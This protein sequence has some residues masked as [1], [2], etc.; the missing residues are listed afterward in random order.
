MRVLAPQLGFTAGSRKSAILADLPEG[1][2]PSVTLCSQEGEI[3]LPVDVTPAERVGHWQ[4]NCFARADFSTIDRPGEYSLEIRWNDRTVKSPAF[5]IDTEVLLKSGASDVLVYFRASRSWGDYERKDAAAS[6]F[7]HPEWGPLDARGG[8]LDASGDQGKYLSHLTYTPTMSPQ[9]TPMCSWALFEARSQLQQHH[10][11]FSKILGS[12]LRDEGLHGADFLVRMC[13]PQGSFYTSVFDSFRHELNEREVCAPL[14]N[15]KKTDR[16][17]A[18]YRGGGGM[19]IAALARASQQE[20]HGTFTST[21][22]LEAATSAFLDLEKNNRSYLFGVN[23]ETG[24]II[25]SSESIVDDYCALLAATEL[26][27]AQHRQEYAEAAMRRFHNLLVRYHNPSDGSPGWFTA[28]NDGRPWFSNVESGLPIVA[29]LRFAEVFHN[30]DV[31]GLDL[32]A[33]RLAARVMKD[34]LRRTAR[35]ANPFGL[36][37]QRVVET[38][39]SAAPTAQARDA[40]FIPH[41]N[42]TGFWWQGENANLASLSV[43][44]ARVASLDIISEKDAARLGEF[45]MDQLEWIIGRNPFGICM[46]QGRGQ[47]SPEYLTEYPN[48]PGG[49]VNGVTADPDDPDAV[50]FLPAEYSGGPDSW[51][52]AEQWI[53]HAGWYLL[54]LSVT[55]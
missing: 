36:A 26:F 9:Q 46:L 34:T 51:R 55:P 29:L 19:A 40:F 24:D 22:Y 17:L 25:G 14:P 39:S 32:D 35:I 42:E 52:W 47:G 21:E 10:P 6:F 13:S 50:A 4:G 31:D 53:P 28:W 41:V 18:S 7:Q 44:A 12:T 43:A 27:A 48:L 3:R 37:R 54:A 2:R 5:T 1:A 20:R 16:C 38:G 15:G 30:V 45:S 33:Q 23:I 11:R 49:I 8:W